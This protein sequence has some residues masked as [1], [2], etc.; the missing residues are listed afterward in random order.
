[1]LISITIIGHKEVAH[2]Q[3]LLPCLEW[4]DE[5][6][7]VDCESK[8]GSL[9]F[10]EKNGCRTFERPNNSNLN[11][12]KSFAMEQAQG[13]WIFYLDPDERLPEPLVQEILLVVVNTKHSAFQ[14]N[15]RNHYFG[16]WLRFG[17]QYPDRQLR[18]FR[19]GKANFPKRHVH[20]KLVI[21][22][23]IGKLKEDM[24]H[25]PYQDIHQFLAKFDFYTDLQADYLYDSGVR[26]G[27]WSGLIFLC[28]KPWIRFS[29]RYLL[30]GGFRD[31]Y[32]GLFCAIFDALNFIVR[33]FKILE[34]MRS[35]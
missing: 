27:F 3:E 6:V 5:V 8:D 19:R 30:K 7:Y 20:E 28:L 11:V 14:L 2:L 31:G 23:S 21:E 12:N 13:E 18:L 26:P 25:Y 9:E 33:Y 29:H 15:R 24:N 32:P 1:M 17:C 22:G 16:K 10:A 4:A 35:N 34:K